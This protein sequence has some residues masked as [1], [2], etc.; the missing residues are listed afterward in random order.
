MKLD[1]G[2]PTPALRD[3]TSLLAPSGRVCQSCYIRLDMT[4]SFSS[5]CQ[6]VAHHTVGVA[7]QA[8]VTVRGEAV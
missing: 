2:P 7:T 4:A 1:I 8:A 6:T 5:D 3:T